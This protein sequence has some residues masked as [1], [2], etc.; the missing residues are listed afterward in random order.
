MFQA[1]TLWLLI[2]NLGCVPIDPIAGGTIEPPPVGL[3]HVSG[4]A[5][6]IEQKFLEKAINSG[7]SNMS[8]TSFH[9]TSEESKASLTPKAKVSNS[10]HDRPVHTFYDHCSLLPRFESERKL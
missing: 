3:R 8:N 1:V 2:H 5:A 10:R 4:H 6:S 7:T 9:R